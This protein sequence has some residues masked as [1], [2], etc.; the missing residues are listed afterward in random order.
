MAQKKWGLCLEER[1]ELIEPCAGLSIRQQCE[2]LGLHRSGVYYRPVVVSA[3]ELEWRR[4]LDR[5][6][7]AHPEF[8]VRRMVLALGDEGVRVN[9]KCVRGLLREMGLEAV[10]PKPR[11]SLPGAVAGRFPYLLRD[12]PIVRPHQ[13]W[14]ADSPC[15]A[16]AGGWAYRVAI[17]EWYSRYVLAW[18]LSRIRDSAFCVQ[19]WHQAVGVAGRTPEIM[20]T[21][22]GA[23]FCGGDWL[24]AVQRTGARIS[25]DGRGRALDNVMVE[26]LWRTVKHEHVYLQDYQ[27]VPGLRQGLKGFFPFYNERRW[28]QGLANQTPQQVLN[29]HP[30][31]EPEGGPAMTSVSLALLGSLRE[32]KQS[33]VANIK[34]TSTGTKDGERLREPLPDGIGDAA[35]I[36]PSHLIGRE[37]PIRAIMFVK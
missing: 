36:Q 26:R 6:H 31:D 32:R 10:Y 22:Q 14:A 15:I 18:E 29:G 35:L 4:R 21:D 33:E 8:G 12:V 11:L 34:S 23:E 9:P 7:T 25:Q 13:V 5:I 3:R 20:N 16:L 27:T 24:Q 17:L 28:H 1:R 37:K 2:L 19:A 30:K